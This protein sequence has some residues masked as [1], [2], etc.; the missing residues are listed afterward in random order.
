[1]SSSFYQRLG[2]APVGGGFE[3]DDYWVWCGSPVRGEDGRYHLFASRWPKALTFSPHWLTNSEIVRASSDTPVGPYRFEEVVLGE[4]DAAL[5]DG[6]MQHNPTIH[7]YNGTYYLYYVGTT[8]TGGRPSPE[9]PELVRSPKALEARANQRIGLATSSSVFGPWKRSDTPILEPRQ[10]R[11]D[12]L[13][14]TNPAPWIREDGSVLLVYKSAADQQDLLRFGI[15]RAPHPTGP[16]ERASEE[17]IFR[18]DETGDHIEDGY[19]W[20]SA[21]K[22]R[23]ELIMKDMKG[24]LSGELHAG[25][26]AY[27]ADGLS[28]TLSQPPKAYSRR[29]RWD[30]GSVTVQASFERPQLLLEN[31]EPAYLFAATAEGPGGFDTAVR[32][33]NMVIPLLAEREEP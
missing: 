9:A 20:W 26:H 12:A 4:R 29:V 3:L 1:M 23:Y 7:Y 18:F 24:G 31:G 33:W 8:Y 11:W 2:D 30:D 27:S 25:V 22:R 5:W 15:A 21:G 19:I 10:G 28:W 6:G 32:T 14:T 16:Y 17:P 13:M